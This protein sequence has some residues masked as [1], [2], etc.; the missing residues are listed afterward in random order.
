MVA[1]RPNNT[2]VSS[3]NLDI[4]VDDGKPN[5]FKVEETKVPQVE[6]KE[7]LP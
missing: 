1:F 5:R 6:Y 4:F 3:F 7:A 2:C